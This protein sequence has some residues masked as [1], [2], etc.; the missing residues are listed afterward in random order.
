MGKTYFIE[1]EV[2]VKTVGGP[3]GIPGR[4][5]V[6][7]QMNELFAKLNLEKYLER[8]YGVSGKTHWVS[9]PS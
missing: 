5:L 3:I 1:Y 2:T 4:I 7:R 9:T 6:K 8:K